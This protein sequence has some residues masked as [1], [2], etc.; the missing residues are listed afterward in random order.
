VYLD[1]RDDNF[2]YFGDATILYALS[3]RPSVFPSLW[4]HEGLSFPEREAA[5]RPVFEQHIAD[6]L[7]RHDVRFVVLDGI[8]TWNGTTPAH[9][10]VLKACLAENDGHETRIGRFQILPIEPDCVRRYRARPGSLSVEFPP[11]ATH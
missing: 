4:F 2:L 11:A 5:E 7:V 8:Q 10:G 6:A 1:A 3:G 9:F